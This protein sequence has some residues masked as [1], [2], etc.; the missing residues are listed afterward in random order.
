M[1]S[2]VR[3]EITNARSWPRRQKLVTTWII[4]FFKFISGLTSSSVVPNLPSIA[5]ELDIPR[6]ALSILPLSAYFLGYSAGLLI[7]GSLSETFGRLG[8]LQAS[9]CIFIIFNTACGFSR[10]KTQL[11]VA[12]ALSGLG[13]AGPLCVSQEIPQCQLG[14][15]LLT[16]RR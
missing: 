4:A 10:T 12:R 1:D 14:L 15:L 6:G 5:A 13:G 2:A 16:Y 9:N 8:T 7:I 11:I 3:T